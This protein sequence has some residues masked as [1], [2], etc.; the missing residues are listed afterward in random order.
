MAMDD[1]TF[2]L[3]PRQRQIWPGAILGAIA[4]AVFTCRCPDL[5]H[6]QSWDGANYNVQDSAGSRGTIAFSG[7]SFVGLF[8][9]ETSNRSP[10]RLGTDHD[11]AQ[12]L[13]GI[14]ARLQTLAREECFPY[15]LQDLNGK[16]MPVATAAFW[17]DG[18]NERVATAE[19]WDEV[20]QH[21]AWLV[22]RQCLDTDAALS[23]W[24]EDFELEPWEV[25]LVR[26]LF[27]QKAASPGERL[28]LN[29]MERKLWDRMNPTE[30]GLEAGR[31]SFA[32][33]GIR[34]P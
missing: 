9:C 11:P 33:M 14:P 31:E 7:D 28:E 4:H 24:T 1:A 5:S 2:S 25:E 19:P 21:G 23:A 12:I 29:Q 18:M 17:G 30:E 6:E 27:A 15:L 3:P 8:F 20:F 26:S 32:E 22:R 10:F 16:K 34:V 13:V